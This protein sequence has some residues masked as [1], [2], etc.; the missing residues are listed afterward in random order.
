MVQTGRRCIARAR[1]RPM[2]SATTASSRTDTATSAVMREM[3]RSFVSERLLDRVAAIEHA[4]ILA[5]QLALNSSD[6]RL[7]VGQGHFIA[8]VVLPIE[9]EQLVRVGAC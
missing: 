3:Y 5:A 2:S 9:A 6:P 7:D 1:I 4:L 8:T